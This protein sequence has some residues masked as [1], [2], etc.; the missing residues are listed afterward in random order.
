MT[1]L[2]VTFF[3]ERAVQIKQGTPK[4]KMVAFSSAESWGVFFVC[5]LTYKGDPY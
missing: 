3:K 4:S 1:D 5:L 2:A